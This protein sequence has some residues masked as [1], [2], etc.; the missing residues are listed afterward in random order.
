MSKRIK[1]LEQK[2][3]TLENASAEKIQKIKTGLYFL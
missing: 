3:A 2:L 1:E